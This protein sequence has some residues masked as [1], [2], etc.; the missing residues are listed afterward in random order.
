MN[1]NIDLKSLWNSQKSDP[2]KIEEVIENAKKYKR[3]QFRTLIFTNCIL[4]LT[5]VFIAFIWIRYEPKMWTTKIG[6]VLTILAMVTY[7][8]VYNKNIFFFKNVDLQSDSKKYLDQLIVYKEKQ[9]FLQ[10]KMMAIY[11]IL[12]SVG[13]GLY[14]IEYVMQMKLLW[15]IIYCFM[16]LAWIAFAWFYLRPK[17]LKKENLNLNNLIEQ[18]KIFE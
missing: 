16:T 13:L 2:P 6:I 3:K 1:D 4:L 10:Q 9:H 11:F 12:L 17:R 18:L 15:G 8:L 5:S 14:M 7:L